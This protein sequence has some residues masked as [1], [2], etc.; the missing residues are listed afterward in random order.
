ML[1]IKDY[2]KV[3]EFKAARTILGK[4]LYPT[5]FF[6]TD[7][8]LI[9][10]GPSHVSRE[11][12]SA[13]KNLP[14]DKIVIT[15]QHEDHTGNC[16]LLER[17]FGI[18]VFA[19]PKAIPV[20]ANP[21]EIEI[22]RK[23]MWGS[24]PRVEARPLDDIIST[25]HYQFITIHTGG[26]SP[27]HV[28]FYEPRNRWLFCGDLYLGEGLTGFMVGENIV[29]H[30]TSLKKLISLKP[31]FLYCGLKGRLDNATERLAN[32]YDS[33]W[34]LCSR[35]KKMYEAKASRKQILSEVFGGEIFFYYFSQ[36]NWGRR[37]M[38]DTIIDNIDFFINE[39][40][41]NPSRDKLKI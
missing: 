41:K 21:P 39:Q 28:C 12:L 24:L 15:H 30:L 10:A 19:H 18:P 27:D 4:P 33:W 20:L 34:E 1:K 16:S 32:K 37:Y 23:I 25:N 11:V 5:H 9:D 14:L 22:Y 36:S 35:V 13:L 26:H 38:I 6:Y 40:K 31:R 3:I 8:L 29:E 2:G 17:E 7:G